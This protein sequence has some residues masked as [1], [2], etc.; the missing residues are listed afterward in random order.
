M[1]LVDHLL[2]LRKRL[3]ISLGAVLGGFLIC[4]GVSEHIFHLLTRP[5]THVL[6]DQGH[7]IFTAPHEAFMTYLKVAAIA[8]L[9]VASPVILWQIWRFVAPGLYLKEKTYFAAVVM[10][11]TFFFVGGA[12]FGYFVVFPIGFEYFID[13]F[14]TP[15]IVAMITLKE[16][17]SFATSL[18]I[19]FGVTFESPVF[20]FF[21][22]RIG[23]VTPQWLWKNFRYAVLIIFVVAAIFTPADALSQMALAVPLTVLYLLATGLAYLVG[24]KKAA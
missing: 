17:L 2:E 5:L 14:Q 4:W 9:L 12:L 21:L 15:E 7:M 13:T 19:A 16:Y 10:V 6:G 22:A 3:L 18:L 24:K 23:L 1:S 20:I 11:G 8:G